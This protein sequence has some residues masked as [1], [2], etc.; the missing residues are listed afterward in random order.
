[1][2]CGGGSCGCGGAC[3]GAEKPP[4]PKHS[5]K[6]TCH[7]RRD[8]ATWSSDGQQAY[9]G[10]SSSTTSG[11]IATLLTK[12]DTPSVV[13]VAD[14]PLGL[15][16]PP[17]LQEGAVSVPPEPGPSYSGAR[18]ERLDDLSWGGSGG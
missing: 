3:G 11:S 16:R 2:A 18:T 12:D 10:G 13:A 7:C 14:L 17:G 6:C 9:P 15:A 4:E 1:M 8:V 5:C